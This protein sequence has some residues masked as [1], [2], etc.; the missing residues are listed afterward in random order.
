LQWSCR[1]EPGAPPCRAPEEYL[2]RL[3]G[4]RA[5]HYLAHGPRLLADAIAA[6]RKGLRKLPPPPWNTPNQDAPEVREAM[7]YAMETMLW[8]MRRQRSFTRELPRRRSP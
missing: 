8:I 7:Q 3:L 5:P 1:T 2:H 4:D 6:A